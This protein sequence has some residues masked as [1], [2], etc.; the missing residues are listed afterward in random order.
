MT[1]QQDDTPFLLAAIVESSDDA[2]VSKDVRGVVRSWN[3]AA[4]RMFGFTAAEMIGQSIRKIIPADRQAEEDRVLAAILAGQ[5][6]DHFET[7]R[8]TRD[9]SL[10]PVSLTVSPIRDAS[11]TVIGASK[12]AR[13]IS[14]RIRAEA[15]AERMARRDGFLAQVTLTLTRSLDYE[16]TLKALA[17]LAVPV[18]ADYCA[19]DVI[20]TD[21]ELVQLAVT[22]VDDAKAR[23]AQEIRARYEDPN[24]SASA[25]RVVRTGVPAFIPNVTDEMVVASARGN[26][27]GLAKIRSLGLVSYMCVPMRAHDRTLGAMTLANAESRTHYTEEDLRLAEDVTARAALAIGNAQSYVELQTANRLKDE[28][29]ATLSHELR[30]PLNA[31]LGYARLLRSGAIRPERT[32]QALDVIERNAGSLAQIVE[33]VLDV[34]RIISGKASL[35]MKPTDIARVVRDAVATVSPAVDAKGIAMEWAI[36]PH[37]GPVSGDP[38]RLQ[39][40]VWNILSNA[41]KFTPKGGRVHIL[42]QP[43]ESQVEIVVSDTGI[44]IPPAFLPHIFERFRQA[45]GGTTR[46]HGGLGLGLAIARHIVEMH[47]GTIEVESAGPGKGSTFRVQLPL[48]SIDGDSY[49]AESAREQNMRR[50]HD[51]TSALWGI[52]VMAVDDD[53]D[54]LKLVREILESAGA[55]VITVTSATAAL[56][57]LVSDRPQVLVSDLGMPGMDGFQLIKQIRQMTDASLRG[58]PAAALTAYARSGDRARS[59]RSGFEM[60]LAKPIDPAELVAAVGALARR[61]S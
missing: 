10:I 5:R 40:V 22:H 31:V 48:M 42:V 60:H 36:D 20:D 17:A 54:A 24:S 52:V 38:N 14:D 33:D 13:D 1:E 26:E 44:G 51:E 47:G 29:L 55:E 46:K 34:S 2:I 15:L 7:M 45:E 6:V 39:Q 25:Q 43:N 12:I 49:A 61:S 35:D 19:V 23:L 28:F 30:T 18:I 37:V 57:R 16:R 53:T 3:R 27:D 21:G 9:G 4:E 58:I 56:D 59:L 8:I 32:T 41:A 11:G 50:A